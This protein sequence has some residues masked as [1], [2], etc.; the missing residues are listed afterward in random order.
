MEGKC[1]HDAGEALQ[2]RP[3]AYDVPGQGRC[4]MR[5]PTS[6]P[7]D[8]DRFLTTVS[9]EREIVLFH[10]KQIIFSQGERGDS[11]FHIEDGSVKL[12]AT[13]ELGKEAIV[14]ILER[15]T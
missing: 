3:S 11:V 15:G 6:K 1:D 5:R 4:K 12:A 7:S 9:P 2:N 14:G 13:S 8:I 10:N